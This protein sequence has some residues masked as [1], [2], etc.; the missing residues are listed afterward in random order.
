MYFDAHTH[1]QFAAFEND[2]KEAIDRARAAG[3]GMILVGTQKDTSAAAVAVSQQYDAGVWAAVGLHPVHTDKSFH[4]AEELGADEGEKGFTSRGE[5]FDY[6]YYKKLALDPKVVAVGECGLDYYRMDA[7]GGEAGE[8]EKKSKQRQAFL[9]HIQLAAEV[10]KPLM[11]HCREAYA[12]LRDILQSEARNLKSDN[13]G[14]IHFFCGTIEEARQFLDLGFS[15]TFGGAIT[16]PPKKGKTAGE[17]DEVV[18]FIPAERIL[19]ETDAPYVTPVPYRGHRNEPS[20]IP[21]IVK[22]LAA[23]KN[24]EEGEMKSVI[25]QNARK[26]FGVS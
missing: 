23:L 12:D 14:V 13:P 10:E 1:I 20:Y 11:I 21:E 17:Y 15:F 26:V 24:M 16:F 22:K 5:I 19:S 8:K 18:R 3:V 2:R 6:D 7:G 25:W 4:D 9:A